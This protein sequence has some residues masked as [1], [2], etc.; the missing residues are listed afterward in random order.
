MQLDIDHK[1]Y[2][3]N[4]LVIFNVSNIVIDLE[5]NKEINICADIHMTLDV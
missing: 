4:I 2:I 5:T 1:V 3:W